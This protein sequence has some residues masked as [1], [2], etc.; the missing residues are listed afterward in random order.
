[1][2]SAS[3][4]TQSTNKCASGA[5]SGSIPTSSTGRRSRPPSTH[6]PEFGSHAGKSCDQNSRQE[7]IKR[8]AE[9]RLRYIESLS[10]GTRASVLEFGGGFLIN[11]QRS[12]RSIQAPGWF[13]G[14]LK[15]PQ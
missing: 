15:P 5:R 6:C 7:P 2:P 9:L 8:A 10:T 3:P 13:E 4:P 12:H 14:E 1:M 11:L